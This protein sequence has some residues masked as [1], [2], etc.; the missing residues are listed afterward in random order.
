MDRSQQAVIHE[1]EQMSESTVAK[2]L[3]FPKRLRRSTKKNRKVLTDIMIVA[4]GVVIGDLI[5]N[6]IYFLLKLMGA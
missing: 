6:L 5:V 2:V 3:K 4:V 1:K